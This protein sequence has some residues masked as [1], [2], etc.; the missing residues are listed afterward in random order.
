MGDVSAWGVRRKGGGGSD[1]RRV[2]AC[3]EKKGRA[4]RQGKRDGQRSSGGGGVG[5]RESAGW[6]CRALQVQGEAGAVRVK[7]PAAVTLRVTE[8]WWMMSTRVQR[9]HSGGSARA[10]ATGS[11]FSHADRSW[12]LCHT[13][14][15]A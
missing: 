3:S 8:H 9:R 11:P 14:W 6:A 12:S 4:C 13:G 7:E 5:E 2:W 1:E 10:A 15:C